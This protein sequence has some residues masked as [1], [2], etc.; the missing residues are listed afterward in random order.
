VTKLV[1]FDMDGVL[2][3]IESSWVH[4]HNHFGV[5]NNHSLQAY[6]DGEI[7]DLE[8]IRRDVA[9]WMDKD[10]SLTMDRIRRILSDAPMMKGAAETIRRLKDMGCKTAIVSAGIDILAERIAVELRMDLFFA[11]GFISDC[12]GRLTGEGILNVGLGE[13][14]EKVDMIADLLGYEK[15][16]VVSVGNSRYDIPMFEVSRIG[17]AFCPI[18]EDVREKADRVIEEKDLTRILDVI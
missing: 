3:D 6:L 5:D 13:K 1:V 10:P 14:G 17:I 4:V 8:F 18:D 7:D 11:N 15:N 2:V 9:L 12:A 16:D